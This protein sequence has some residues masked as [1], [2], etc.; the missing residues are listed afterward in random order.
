MQNISAASKLLGRGDS[1]SGDTQEITL[2]SG[3]T[4][5]GTTLSASGGGGSVSGSG[6]TNTLA[7]WTA[8]TTLGDSPVIYDNTN[9]AITLDDKHL[10]M[11]DGYSVYL[12]NGGV[13]LN[14]TGLD[15]ILMLGS[16]TVDAMAETFTIKS[17]AGSTVIGDGESV[18]FNGATNTFLNSITLATSSASTPSLNL[19]DGAAPSS[20]VDWDIWR[21]GDTVYLRDGGTTRSITFT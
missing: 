18:S 13:Y 14:P 20:P 5:T 3:L 2:G 17:E 12:L 21:I 9:G 11:P 16:I 10:S 1:G 4:M 19:P 8:S 15:P 6:T 7:M